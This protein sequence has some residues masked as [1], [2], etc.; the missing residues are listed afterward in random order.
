MPVAVLPPWGN[1][2]MIGCRSQ[3]LRAAAIGYGRLFVTITVSATT[4]AA[5]LV[6][7]LTPRRAV[8]LPLYA[9]QTGQ[10]CATCHT[11]FLELTPFGRRFKLGGYTLDGGDWS[12]PPLPSCCSRPL[13][14][15]K[16]G[17]REAP[18]P[19]SG[20]TTMSRCNR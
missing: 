10:S 14:I 8:S 19:I 17:K 16:P 13:P 11:A 15:P 3:L 2:G 5:V 4:I 7:G 1:I 9:R 20:R 6:I 12:G 18:P